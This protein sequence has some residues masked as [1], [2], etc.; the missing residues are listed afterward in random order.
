MMQFRFVF[1]KKAT[2]L[3]DKNGNLKIQVPVHFTT[4]KATFNPQA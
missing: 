3:E 2:Q 1:S 4:R